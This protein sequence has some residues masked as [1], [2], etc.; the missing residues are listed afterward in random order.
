MDVDE[1]GGGR[2]ALD[3]ALSELVAEYVGVEEKFLVRTWAYE[4]SAW[5]G[6]FCLCE[7]ER[8]REREREIR[9]ER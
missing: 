6:P 5:C 8:E 1:L 4:Q 2:R 3:T 7:R 9:D